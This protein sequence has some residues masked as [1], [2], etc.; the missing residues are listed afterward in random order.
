MKYMDEVSKYMKIATDILF[1]KNPI[2]T[3]L[4]VLFGIIT[5]GL[6]GLF[7]P[8]LQSFSF[9]KTTSVSFYHFLALGVFTFN[10]KGWINQEKVSLEIE[11]ALSFIREQEKNGTIT[12]MEAKQQYRSLIH[13]AVS[14]I[15]LKNE[16]AK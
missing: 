6:F 16:N 10:I 5:Y 9:I 15:T 14:N 7:S 1:V 8:L 12:N 3:S 11:N 4:G 13:K 2:G